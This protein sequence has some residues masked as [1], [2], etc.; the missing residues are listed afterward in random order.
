MARA[1]GN[2]AA[3]GGFPVW[4]DCEA[5]VRVFRAMT[6]QWRTAIRPDGKRVFDGLRYESLPT[7]AQG[8]GVAF[9]EQ[10]FE[11]LRLMEA[12]ALTHIN[13]G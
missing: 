2:A 6:T 9:G 12:E 3:S 11:D 8:L 7:V 1:R 4:A 5:P 10:L 13:K